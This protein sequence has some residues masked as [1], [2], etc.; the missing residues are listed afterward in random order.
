MSNSYVGWIP[1]VGGRLSFSI[2]GNSYTT[3]ANKSDRSKRYILSYQSKSLSDSALLP[4]F[5]WPL[6]KKS[7]KFTFVCTGTASNNPANHEAPFQGQLIVFD[8]GDSGISD[9]EKELKKRQRNIQYGNDSLELI[10]TDIESI[11]D[12]Q[13]QRAAL[14]RFD[15]CL[16][17]DG[18][19]CI[20]NPTSK[21]GLE[22][23][24]Q[25]YDS[26]AAQAFFFLK[27]LC[28]VH[29][30]HH[31]QT[32]TMVDLYKDEE[33][34]PWKEETIRAL[35]RHVLSYKRNPSIESYTSAL[36]VL[37]YLK[38]FISNHFS[39]ENIEEDA[40]R[41]LILENENIE[42]SILI[43]KERLHFENDNYRSFKLSLAN[44]FFLFIALVIS[45][46]GMGQIY[47]VA[48][49]VDAEND[50]LKPLLEFI[51]AEPIS[52][53]GISTAFAFAFTMFV[54]K[55]LWSTR[56]IFKNFI[57]LFIFIKQN[58]LGTGLILIGLLTFNTAFQII[59][60]HFGLD[61]SL[62]GSIKGIINSWLSS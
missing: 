16:Q 27:D 61:V 7:S 12:Y 1:T 36:G 13:V 38:T 55:D 6:L 28:H 24:E 42:K 32:D 44:L 14:A 33:A 2:I 39:D 25:G 43:N 17:R 31:S 40:K 34:T 26:L 5:I 3:T 46:S 53:L 49:D 54:H 18:K 19:V 23:D 52:L 22:I 10:Q 21:E 59:S 51:Y 30:H 37:A 35:Y 4:D 41:S 60:D 20:N 47:Q 9:F 57:R 58:Y 45:L 29:Q 62:S 50:Y 56:K 48:L 11:V 15:F 8:K